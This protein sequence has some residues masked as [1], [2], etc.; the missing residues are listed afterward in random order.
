MNAVFLTECIKDVW[1]VTTHRAY[2]A[3]LAIGYDIKWRPQ[4]SAEE[5]GL[6]SFGKSD[7]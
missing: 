2:R 3:F 1:K 4:K 7:R 6:I 5:L